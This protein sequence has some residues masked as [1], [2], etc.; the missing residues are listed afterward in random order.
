MVKIPYVFYWIKKGK[1]ITFVGVVF[2]NWIKIGQKMNNSIVIF[3]FI[4]EPLTSET[5]DYY[6]KKLDSYIR[7]M[8]CQ[9]FFVKN[10]Q[11]KVQ[12]N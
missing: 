2:L 8:I 1:N 4:L 9:G 3:Y 5:I 10:F 11:D 7:S 12:W 6:D